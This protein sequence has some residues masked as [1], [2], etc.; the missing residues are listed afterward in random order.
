MLFP[1][2]TQNKN[3]TRFL[4][5]LPA[6]VLLKVC[7]VE[8]VTRCDLWCVSVCARVCGY[9]FMQAWKTDVVVDLVCYRKYGHNEI[10]EPMFTQV[11]KRAGVKWYL[12]DQLMCV[13]CLMC[14]DVY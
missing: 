11:S 1:R 9:V 6:Q 10:D 4:H 13:L 14:V 2:W 12:M 5:W 8:R 7:R 3:N